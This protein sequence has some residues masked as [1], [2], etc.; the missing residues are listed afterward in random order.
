MHFKFHRGRCKDQADLLLMFR[1]KQVGREWKARVSG[2]NSRV[3]MSFLSSPWD[4][5]RPLN[6]RVNVNALG[7]AQEVLPLGLPEPR[8]TP[9]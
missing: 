4:H 1:Q 7:L 5:Q 3:K 6:H 2:W 8:A 9:P